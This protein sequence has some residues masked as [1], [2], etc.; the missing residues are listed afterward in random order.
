MMHYNSLA[1]AKYTCVLI[2]LLSSM[3]AHASLSDC[4]SLLSDST[5]K[6]ECNPTEAVAI[7]V[8]Q[9]PTIN[10]ATPTAPAMG[11]AHSDFYI[12]QSSSAHAVS[13]T[14]SLLALLSGLLVV[15]LMRAKRFNTK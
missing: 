2:A 5:V 11:S 6:L 4:K 12:G 13:E 3:T 7:K 1:S 14:L 9:T 10:V 8:T 15:A